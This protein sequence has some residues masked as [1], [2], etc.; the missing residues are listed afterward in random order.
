MALWTNVD[1]NAG[2]PKF[3]SD[4]DKANTVGID[5]TEATANGLTAGWNLKTTGSG[6]RSGR[7]LHEV[8]VAMGSMTGD[9]DTI[10][11]EITISAQPADATKA[12]GESHTFSVTASRTGTGTL[13]YT[14]QKAESTAPTVWANIVGAPSTNTYSTGILSSADNGDRYRVIVSLVGAE[15]VTSTAATLTVA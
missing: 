4:A 10:A 13:A 6:G 14:W 11:P 1:E 7:V 8:L 12:I 3:L 5:A 9:N 2:K 15:S